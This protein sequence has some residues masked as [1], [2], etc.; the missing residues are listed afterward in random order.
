LIQPELQVALGLETVHPEI[1]PKLNKQMTL[2][3]FSKA[4]H[5]LT[6]NRIRSR[7]F[8]LLRPPF[9]SESE[10]EYWAKRSIDFAFD[11]GIECCTVIPVRAGNGAMDLLMKNGDFTM[12]DIHS[13]ERVMEYGIGIGAG[14]VFV[15]VWDLE[16]FSKCKNCIDQRTRRLT[17][18]NLR[19]RIS[20]PVVC[21][22]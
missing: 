11:V 7:A 4:A 13:L 3:D 20:K 14:R 1:L 12:P 16:L 15:D 9:L 19:Q 8:I 10:G 2:D 17:T 5:Y 18:M 22:C 21:T 6:Q